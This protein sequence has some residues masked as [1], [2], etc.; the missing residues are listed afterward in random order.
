MLIW[1]LVGQPIFTPRNLLVSLP[2]VA[3]LLGWVIMSSRVSPVAAW[4]AV[5]S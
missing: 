2:A 4:G 5:A 1:S 3:L